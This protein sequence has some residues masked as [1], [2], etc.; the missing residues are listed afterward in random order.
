MFQV[1]P[2]DFG[3]HLHWQVDE[4][5]YVFG[6]ILQK[7]KYSAFLAKWKFLCQFLVCDPGVNTEE[8]NINIVVDAS[9]RNFRLFT[10]STQEIVPFIGDVQV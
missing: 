6:K 4:S 2:N 5:K 1:S 9:C 7:G 10:K 8:E 3:F